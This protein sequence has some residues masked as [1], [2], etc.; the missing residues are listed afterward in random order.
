[1]SVEMQKQAGAFSWNELMTTDIEGA[2][3]FYGELFGWKLNDM[4]SAGPRYAIASVGGR[5]VAGIMDKPDTAS[6]IPSSW[7]G[8]ITVD[9]V[10]SQVKKAQ[11]LGGTVL[12]E[13]QDIPNIGRF[14]VVK[15]PQGAFFSMIS[16]FPK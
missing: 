16:Y 1:M 9:N 7:G 8:Y 5:E 14:S 2:K 4:E 15:D 12:V 10:D 6:K 13:P 3:V 11:S